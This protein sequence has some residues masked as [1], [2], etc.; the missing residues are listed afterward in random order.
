MANNS[1]K[2]KLSYESGFRRQSMLMKYMG[3]GA[4]F[5]ASI[6]IMLLI[7]WKVDDWLVFS[8]PVFIWLLPLLSIVVTLIKIILETNKKSKK[9]E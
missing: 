5:F 3:L 8:T 7:G 6:L 2:R 9:D 1:N 4:Q